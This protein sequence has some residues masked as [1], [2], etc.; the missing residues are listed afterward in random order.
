MVSHERSLLT[1]AVMLPTP[2]CAHV[3]RGPFSDVYDPA[4]DSFLM[5]DALERDAEMLRRL[6]C[7]DVNPAAV[8]C[9]MET[10]RCNDVSLQPLIT[11]L[12]EAI[13]PR[14]REN[15]DVL[16][17]NPPYVVTPTEEVGSHSIEASWAGGRRGREV[18]DRLFPLVPQLLSSQ[19]LFYLVTVQDNDPEEILQLL[20]QSGLRGEVCISRQ[21][22]REALSILRFCKS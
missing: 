22:G 9:T 16:L 20:G 4:E 1:G 12:V 10:A 18:M 3:G 11:D 2:V 14:L 21:A 5:M 17:F 13:L 15:V 6:N 7:T 19:G 8:L